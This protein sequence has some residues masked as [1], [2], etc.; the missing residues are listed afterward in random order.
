MIIEKL[1]DKFSS[2]ST[3]TAKKLSIN[4]NRNLFFNSNNKNFIQKRPL[5]S[6]IVIRKEIDINLKR[7]KIDNNSFYNKSFNIQKTFQISPITNLNSNNIKNNNINL[8]NKR[9]KIIYENKNFFNELKELKYAFEFSD[10]NII[11][12]KYYR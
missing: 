11:I 12:N 4:N 10:C 1:E 3:I 6:F 2:L 9:K 8:N 5:S 7:T